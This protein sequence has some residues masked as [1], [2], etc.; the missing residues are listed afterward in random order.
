MKLQK[1][2]FVHIEWYDIVGEGPNWSEDK[3]DD[4]LPAP[5]VTGGYILQGWTQRAKYLKVASSMNQETV[6]DK[7][8]YPKGAIKDI[9]LLMRKKPDEF[10]WV[11]MR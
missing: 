3:D 5:C 8:A 10:K 2:D 7:T 11:K 4:L 1:F 9:I 6:S